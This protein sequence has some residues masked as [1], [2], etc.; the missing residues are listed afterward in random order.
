MAT[1]SPS[2]D[3]GG[4]GPSGAVVSSSPYRLDPAANVT[5]QVTAPVEANWNNLDSASNTYSFVAVSSPTASM[6]TQDP[7]WPPAW[8]APLHSSPTSSPRRQ[9]MPPRAINMETS[10][11]LGGDPT[12]SSTPTAGFSSTPAA[13]STTLDDGTLL[14][15]T[16]PTMCRRRALR[17]TKLPRKGCMRSQVRH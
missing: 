4:S 3:E 11:R 8:A 1:P 12:L 16:A 2:G 17:Q 9:P 7:V 13:A 5:N 6:A 15:N 14:R 10:P